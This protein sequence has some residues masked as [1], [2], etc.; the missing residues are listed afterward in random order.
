MPPSTSN[1]SYAAHLYPYAH[2]LPTI[3]P[4]ILPHLP[5]RTHIVAGGLI[6]QPPSTETQEP[7]ILLLR[8]ALT[9]SLPGIWEIPGGSCDPATDASVLAGAAREIREE[10][11][12]MVAR[13]VELV[14]V[15]E[16]ERVRVDGVRKVVKFTF[17]VE[18]EGPTSISGDRG[19]GSA[20]GEVGSGD[21]W[22]RLD[23]AEHDAFVWATEEEVRRGFVPLG[24]S[25][26]EEAGVRLRFLETQRRNYLEGFR[27]F[28]ASCSDACK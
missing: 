11:G 6:F 27:V 16:W 9:D 13:F 24:E 12:L 10:T 18:V 4:T 25:D 1:F 21:C 19:V 14:A 26:G 23:P 5:P 7:K 22:I 20:P 17:L 3:I 8:R 2:P 15:D 28:A